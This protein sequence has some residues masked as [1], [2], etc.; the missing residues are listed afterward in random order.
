MYASQGGD[1]TCNCFLPMHNEMIFVLLIRYL[2]V[3]IMCDYLHTYCTVQVHSAVRYLR[4]LFTLVN[5]KRIRSRSDPL[6]QNP[7][8]LPRAS[9]PALRIWPTDADSQSVP[10]SP[11]HPKRKGVFQ[12]NSKP[13]KKDFI[14]LQRDDSFIDKIRDFSKFECDVVKPLV[15][16]Y[17]TYFWVTA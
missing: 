2:P 17:L 13:A 10:A 6:F 15:L 14:P 5:D 8:Q 11:P 7:D 3:R 4:P 12:R 1:K 9:P 16:A